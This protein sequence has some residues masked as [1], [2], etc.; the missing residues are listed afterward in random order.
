MSK[1][2][3]FDIESLIGKEI[4]WIGDTGQT[5]RAVVAAVV[6]GVGITLV[7]A[8]DKELKLTCLHG[9]NSKGDTTYNYDVLFPRI[10]EMIKEGVYDAIE[11]SE[12]A[13]DHC[14]GGIGSCAF[15]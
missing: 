5:R 12:T 13:D 14:Y 11:T 3:E 6:E 4:D 1:Q 7:D 2:E 15:G 8:K 10:I 9:P